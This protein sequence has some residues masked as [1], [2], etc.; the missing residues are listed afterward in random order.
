[1]ENSVWEAFAP[2]AHIP[3]K[4]EICRIHSTTHGSFNCIIVIETTIYEPVTVYVA[5]DNGSAFM[6]D[7]FSQSQAIL[8]PASQLKIETLTQDGQNNQRLFTSR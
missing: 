6:A 2:F 5:S 7:R 4:Y 1:M 8:I 3:N